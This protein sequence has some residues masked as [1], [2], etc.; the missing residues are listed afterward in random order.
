MINTAEFSANSEPKHLQV[1]D[2]PIALISIVGHI[3]ALLTY[4]NVF[5]VDTKAYVSLGYALMTRNGLTTFYD[6]FGTWFYSHIQPGLPL[7]WLA[8][9][10]LPR[11]L[12]WPVL[13]LIQHTI[14]AAALYYFFSALNRHWPSRWNYAAT[15]VIVLLPFYQAPH[16][17]PMTESLSGSLFLIGLTLVLHMHKGE[18]PD[19]WKALFLALII[20]MVTQLRSYFGVILFAT[21]IISMFKFRVSAIPSLSGLALT[22]AVSLLAFPAYRFTQTGSFWLPTLGVNKLISGWWS[23]PAPSLDTLLVLEKYDF[24]PKL[25]P[26]LSFNNGLTA[27]QAVEIAQYWRT[28]GLSDREIDSRATEAGTVLANDTWAVISNRSLFALSSSGLTLHYCAMSTETIVFPQYSAAKMC[29]HVRQTYQYQSW[30]SEMDYLKRFDTYFHLT[31]SKP[32]EIEPFAEAAKL[33]IIEDSRD[34]VSSAN[35]STRDPLWFGKI[36]P[37]IFVVLALMSMA[38]AGRERRIF[39]LIFAT[40]ILVNAAVCFT[41]PLGNPRYG[42]FLFPVYIGFAFM[43]AAQLNDWSRKKRQ[44]DEMAPVRVVI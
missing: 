11:S 40:C 21:S 1:S 27:A 12:H 8:I 19:L 37:D 22:L 31:P 25:S 32:T 30:L 18:R 36:P 23:N 35:P 20:L 15:L 2:I 26:M 6:G 3:W 38:L 29:A 39:S 17:S 4:G 41:A 9:N 44:K 43:G 5:W 28:I 16:N 24:P 13:A 33:S 42:Y 10:Q 34:Y 14:A 7:V